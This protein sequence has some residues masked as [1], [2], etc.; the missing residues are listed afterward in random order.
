MAPSGQLPFSNTRLVLQEELDDD[1][2]FTGSCVVRLFHSPTSHPAVRQNLQG[3]VSRCA[4]RP[5]HTSPLCKHAG[6]C[7][8]TRWGPRDFQPA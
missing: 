2:Y 4:G 3:L 6:V 8:S 7:S 5:L 1:S